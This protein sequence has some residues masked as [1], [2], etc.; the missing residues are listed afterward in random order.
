VARLAFRW[1]HGQN[2]IVADF[3]TT[4]KNVS[5]GGGTQWI[6]WDPVAKKVRSW[7]FETSGGFGEGS[8]TKDGNT[9]TIKTTATLPDGT[10]ASATNVITHIDPDTITLSSK[11]RRRD[12]KE[13][14]DGKEVRMKRRK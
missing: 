9:W 12:G 13:V 10:K 1:S 2:F 7:S 3:T 14:P 4:F 11:D 6:G 5:Q 8:W